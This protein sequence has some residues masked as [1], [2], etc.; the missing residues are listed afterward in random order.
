[1]GK[2]RK[3]LTGLGYAGSMATGLFTGSIVNRKVYEKTGSVDAANVAGGATAIGITY[4]GTKAVGLVDKALNP[5]YPEVED[6]E[7]KNDDKM[8]M[9]EIADLNDLLGKYH[10][11]EIK[12]K[13]EIYEL[14]EENAK[15]KERV[16]AVQAQFDR[17][18]NETLKDAA[19]GKDFRD[20]IKSAKKSK[21]ELNCFEVFNEDTKE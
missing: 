17:L 4:A 13:H 21:D 2:A 19:T 18:R 10:D 1:M 15:L 6:E 16:N 9:D 3:I 11:N 7:T 20:A 14:E 12:L 5:V 8:L